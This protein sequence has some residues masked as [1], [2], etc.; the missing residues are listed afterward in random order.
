MFI[1]NKLLYKKLNYTNFHFKLIL[2]SEKW[3]NYFTD[4]ANIFYPYYLFCCYMKRVWLNHPLMTMRRRQIS[5]RV[6]KNTHR[7]WWGIS[8]PLIHWGRCLLSLTI[9]WLFILKMFNFFKSLSLLKI[10]FLSPIVYYLFIR[11]YFSF[12]DFSTQTPQNNHNL[13]QDC[14]E[15]Y[16]ISFHSCLWLILNSLESSQVRREKT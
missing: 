14:E 6:L 11:H 3:L 7:I 15:D 16:N 13:P 10:N 12:L 4:D 5:L 9:H 2:W 8:I 1:A